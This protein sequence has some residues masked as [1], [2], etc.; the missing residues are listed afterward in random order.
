MSHAFYRTAQWGECRIPHSGDALGRSAKLTVF[1][2]ASGL[3]AVR[4]KQNSTQ[5]KSQNNKYSYR[6]FVQK[7]HT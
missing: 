1:K 3:L 7:N 4:K 2:I 6:F 5:T